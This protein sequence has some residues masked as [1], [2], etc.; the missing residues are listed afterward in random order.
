MYEFNDDG[1]VYRLLWPGRP[2]QRHP[3][4]SRGL[5]RYHDRSH[6]DLPYQSSPLDQVLAATLGGRIA[7]DHILG[8]SG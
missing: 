2:S 5:V 6:L 7:F 3:G 1:S 4:C 8:A